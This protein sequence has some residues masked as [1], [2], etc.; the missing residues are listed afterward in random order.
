MKEKLNGGQ[1][2]LQL[3]TAKAG[4]ISVKHLHLPAEEFRPIEENVSRLRRSP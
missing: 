4:R 2:D 3:Q 1:T